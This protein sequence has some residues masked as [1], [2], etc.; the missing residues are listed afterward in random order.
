MMKKISDIVITTTTKPTLLD[1]AYKNNRQSKPIVIFVHGF[2]GFKDWG[3]F[4]FVH[5][6]FAENDFISIKFNFSFNGGTLQNPIDFPDLEAFGKNT[7][8][9]ELED[10]GAVIDWVVDNENSY[11]PLE[12]KNTNEIYLVGHS[13]GGGIVILKAYEDNRVKKIV[14]WAAVSDFSKRFPK[15]E[16]LETWKNNGVIYITNS[17]TKQQMPMYYTFYEDFLQNKDRLD[18][19]KAEKN[20]TIPHLIIHGENDEAVDVSEAKYLH[21]LNPSSQLLIV[22]RAGHTFNVKHPFTDNKL[23]QE[24]Q[25]VLDNTIEFLKK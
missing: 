20:L 15:G 11:V 18:I 12:E 21:K 8:T 13:R 7:Y 14:T 9:K 16:E 24:A 5:Q 17:R 3:H 2:K 22:P 19:P 10:L 23:P 4:N 6:Q 1:V 25:I